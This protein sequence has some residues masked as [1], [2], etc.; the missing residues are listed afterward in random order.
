MAQNKRRY[1]EDYNGLSP[2]Y[3]KLILQ[4]GHCRLRQG[5]RRGDT[6]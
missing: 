3:I 4:E 5:Y 2:R 1:T 6:G